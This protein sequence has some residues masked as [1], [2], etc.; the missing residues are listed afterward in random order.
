MAEDSKKALWDAAIDGLS[1]TL[2]TFIENPAQPR[3]YIPSAPEVVGARQLA[4]VRNDDVAVDS[5]AL[6]ATG[7]GTGYVSLIAGNGRAFTPEGDPVSVNILKVVNTL[8]RG[9]VNIVESP[10]PLNERLTLQQVIDLAAKTQDFN[11]EWKIASPVDGL[12]P[13]VYQN[14]PRTLLSDGVW[15]HLRFPL[16]TDSAA[17]VASVAESRLLRDVTTTVSPVSRVSYNLVEFVDDKFR[18][19]AASGQAHGLSKGNRVVMRKTDGTEVFGTVHALTTASD[20]FVSVDDGQNAAVT[21]LEIADLNERI[22]RA[23]VEVREVRRVAAGPGTRLESD[24][25]LAGRLRP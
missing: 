5:Y 18:F 23:R 10:N 16:A 8:Y 13:A 15:T 6:S 21:P 25:Q 24:L 19:R 22:E 14:T 4:R 1:T 7:P 9:E 2:E 17:A 12:P 11:F 3:T 20:I